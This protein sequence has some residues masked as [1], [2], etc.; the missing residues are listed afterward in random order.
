MNKEEQVFLNHLSDLAKVCYGREIP[1]YTDFLNLYEQTVFLSALPEFSH[2]RVHLDGGYEEAERKVVCFLPVYMEALNREMLPIVPIKIS[3]S[4]GKFTEAASH[5][6]Y[7]GAILNLGID[8]SKIGDILVGDG[9]A[10]VLCTAPMAQFLM[11]SLTSV[12]HNPVHCEAVAFSELDGQISF[13]E[14]TGSVASL[15]LDS[16]LALA[17]RMSRSAALSCV[18]EERVYINGKLCTSQTYEP[19]VGDVISV[20]GAGKFIYDGVI[21]GTKKGRQMIRLRKYN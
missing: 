11:D 16:F 21:S 15:R 12:R 2:I 13:T 4:A 3:S 14:I 5:R 17:V 20:R 1:V 8:R 18:R 9:Y 7:L 6:D 19:K 10:Y